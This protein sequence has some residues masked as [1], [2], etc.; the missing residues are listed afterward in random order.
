MN[1][2]QRITP[3]M[4]FFQSVLETPLG[5]Q[6]ET[7]TESSQQIEELDKQVCWKLKGIVA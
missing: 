6:Y 7:P 3:W 1:Q 5:P 2:P 4:S